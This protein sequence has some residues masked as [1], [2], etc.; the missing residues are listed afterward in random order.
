MVCDITEFRGIRS[1]RLETQDYK[2]RGS[3]GEYVTAK[4][5]KS[6]KGSNSGPLTILF[7][8]DARGISRQALFN[9]PRLHAASFLRIA[10]P[11]EWSS[12]RV[13]TN[14]SATKKFTVK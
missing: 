14:F 1:Q 2:T 8:A 13:Q 3:N 6:I 10:S 11:G 9:I 5:K 12:L 4:S 7:F